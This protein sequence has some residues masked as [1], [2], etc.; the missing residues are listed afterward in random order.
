[1]PLS[2]DEQLITLADAAR[3]CPA[4]TPAGH[5]SRQTVRRWQR[6]GVLVGTVRVKLEGKRCGMAWLTTREAVRRFQ[7]ELTRLSALAAGQPAP[8]SWDDELRHRAACAEM[9]AR[10]K[11]GRRAAATGS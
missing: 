3:L 1:M 4:N 2:P 11:R 6:L 5:V 9:D 8:L 10:R 7:D